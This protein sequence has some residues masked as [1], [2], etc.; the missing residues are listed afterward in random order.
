MSIKEILSMKHAVS[1]FLFLLE[2]ED[3]KQSELLGVI[4]SN[5]TIEKLTKALEEEGYLVIKKEFAGRRVYHFSLTEKGRRMAEQLK[6]AEDMEKGN[7]E[8]VPFEMPLDFVQTISGMGAM[9]HFNVKDDHVAVSE[10]NF[11]GEGN[12]RVVFVYTRPN[13]HNV[14]RL[15]CDVDQSFDCKHTR[16]A[17]TIPDV[18]ELMEKIYHDRM[19]RNQEP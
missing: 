9:T 12:N 11:D 18:Q 10:Y 15:W 6:R 17:W 8:N 14:M 13:G 4:P 2:R 7:E 1:L 5:M 16:F 19:T 3:V